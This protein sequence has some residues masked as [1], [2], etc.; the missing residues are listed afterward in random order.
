MYDTSTRK[1]LTVGGAA[2]FE[3]S[4]A[5]MNA[6]VITIG[7]L[8]TNPGDVM[9]QSISYARAFANGVVLP[10]DTVL[11][12]GRRTYAKPF[13]DSNAVLVPKLWDPSTGHWIQLDL[14]ATSRTYHSVV[15]IMPDAA[16]VNGGWGIMRSPYLHTIWPPASVEP[17]QREDLRTSIPPQCRWHS[18]HLTS[19]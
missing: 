2:D 5:R 11:I 13:Q 18:K 10:D 14:L 3:N 19:H 7:T 16:V 6:Y 4:T 15:I 9:A 17:L 8:K 1:I 12:T